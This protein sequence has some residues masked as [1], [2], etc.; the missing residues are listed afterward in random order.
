[1]TFS[2]LPAPFDPLV[3]ELLR[4][5][6]GIHTCDS[7]P[8]RS[9]ISTHFP[10]RI[11]DSLT[12]TD[13]LYSPDLREPPRAHTKRLRRLLDD[14]FTG[15]SNTYISMTSHSGTIG[16]TLAAVGHRAV[17]IGTGGVIPVLVKVVK[18]D[19]PRDG[20][21]EDDDEPWETKPDCVG[22]PLRARREGFEHYRDIAEF[23][24]EIE[25]A[26]PVG[27]R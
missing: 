27:D 21:D 14:V 2:S 22:D 10:F 20:K 18:V 25:R 7:R 17:T 26:V 24:E 3:K 11:E 15:D 8:T 5:G 9:Y 19:G 12:E 23:V 16:A 1:M 4:E 6:H 13:E